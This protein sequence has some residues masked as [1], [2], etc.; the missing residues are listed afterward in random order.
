MQIYLHKIC[1]AGEQIFVVTSF[2]SNA[3]LLKEN[4]PLGGVMTER[5]WKERHLRGMN[6][7]QLRGDS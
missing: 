7:L 5:S 1:K 4:C 2:L 3:M 6:F